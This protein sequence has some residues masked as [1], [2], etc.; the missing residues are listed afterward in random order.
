[1]IA[2]IPEWFARYLP[3]PKITRP[4][5]IRGD[6]SQLPTI[7]LSP[8]KVSMVVGDSRTFD[9]FDTNGAIATGLTW[10]VDDN[11][12][13]S[14]STADPP[15]LT[16][17]SVGT[18]S[19]TAGTATPKIS[20]VT[21]GTVV[22]EVALPPP[23]VPMLQ[24]EDGS[25]IGLGGS[26]FTGIGQVDGNRIVEFK[27]DGTL[28]WSKDVR[29][30]SAPL[31]V[32]AGGG[33]LY[34]D[35]GQYSGPAP[36][37]VRLD[38]NGQEVSR[39]TDNGNKYSW[40]GVYKTGSTKSIA[41]PLALLAP[42]FGGAAGRNLT[43]N[44]FFLVH[45]SF[46]IVFCNTGP[47]GDGSCP[48]RDVTNMSF[49]YLPSQDLYKTNYQT[50]CDFS[51]AS[52]CDGNTAHSEWAK[53][54]KR[55]ALKAFQAAFTSLPAIVGSYTPV[56]QYGGSANP[57]FEHTIYVDG[58]WF[59][60]GTGLTKPGNSHYSWAFYPNLLD[61]AEM[62]LGPYGHS[63][64]FTPPFSDETSMLKLLT[65]LGRGIGNTA[66]HEVGWQLSQPGAAYD[67]CLV[68]GMDCTSNTCEDPHVYESEG[69]DQW[70]FVDSNPPIHWQ[71]FNQRN[72][73]K[74]L[75]NDS[76]CK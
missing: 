47:D 75:V 57:P 24:R 63:V 73:G 36:E 29:Y 74:Y 33:V 2:R 69:A 40:K 4:F 66:A 71:S 68:G 1:V 38:A 55:E 15:V 21:A 76:T 59:D 3:I 16:A 14:L 67:K 70:K 53:V 34:R 8:N 50:A 52:P 6:K 7:T 62:A 35:G 22:S 39:S 42:S 10:T 37:L 46:G 44:G 27:K 13:V 49:S 25:F 12:V 11:S 58:S 32:L 20:T 9:A 45:H 19:I 61:A 30:F 26:R 48:N 56:M 65:A 72:I 5:V 43:G 18:T 17:L 60:Q 54:V 23:V 64:H 41:T 28:L 51:Y 31:Y